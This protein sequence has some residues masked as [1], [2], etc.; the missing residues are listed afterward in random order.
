MRDVALTNIVASDNDVVH[1]P[2]KVLVLQSDSV[3]ESRRS[4][5]CDKPDEGLVSALSR[6]C[7]ETSRCYER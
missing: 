6:R 4:D 3:N 5:S 2:S 1:G 7:E